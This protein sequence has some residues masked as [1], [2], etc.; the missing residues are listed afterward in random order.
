[1]PAR[2]Y[3]RKPPDPAWASKAVCKGS[4][5]HF[6]VHTPKWQRREQTARAKA[7]CVTCPVQSECLR[8]AIENNENDGVWGGYLFPLGVR[9]ARRRLS[10]QIDFE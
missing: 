3:A 7:V 4:T 5:I 6:P 10:L 9:A 2:R 1:M 8:H